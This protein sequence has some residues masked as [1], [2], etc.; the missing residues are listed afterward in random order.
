MIAIKSFRD[1]VVIF[2]IFDYLGEECRSLYRGLKIYIE[3]L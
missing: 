1:I 2:R 3:V